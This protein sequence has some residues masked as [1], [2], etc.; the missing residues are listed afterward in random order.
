M[1]HHSKG[2]ARPVVEFVEVVGVQVGDRQAGLQQSGHHGHPYRISFSTEARSALLAL[3]E[4]LA[5]EVLDGITAEL[6]TDPHGATSSP[7]GPA[8]TLR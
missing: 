8:A 5:Q 4:L 3:G 6:G 2:H 1:H 7:K